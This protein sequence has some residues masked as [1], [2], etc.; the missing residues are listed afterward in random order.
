[1]RGGNYGRHRFTCIG[2]AFVR[3]FQG[4]FSAEA[5]R[6][7]PQVLDAVDSCVTPAMNEYLLREFTVDEVGADLNQMSPLKMP[8]P[9]GFS[10]VF[11]KKIG[12][13]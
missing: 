5:P 1:M 8:E 4:L 2:E 12:Q 10:H 11:F 9:D 13:P 7:M 6:H 3:Y